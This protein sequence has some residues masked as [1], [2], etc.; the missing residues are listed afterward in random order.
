MHAAVSLALASLLLSLAKYRHRLALLP[1]AAVCQALGTKSGK[2]STG[3]ASSTA[4]AAGAPTIPTV[5]GTSPSMR[6][7]NSGRGSDSSSS[8]AGSLVLQDSPAPPLDQLMLAAARWVAHLPYVGHSWLGKQ[9]QSRPWA[10]HADVVGMAAGGEE[11]HAHLL[12]GFFMQ[13]GQQVRHTADFC[14][15]CAVSWLECEPLSGGS[16]WVFLTLLWC[17]MQLRKYS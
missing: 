7:S 17:W 6:T 14:C 12:A 10:V 2:S 11:E 13:L 5:L 16:F 9:Q 3:D 15:C 4:A 8:G 1:S